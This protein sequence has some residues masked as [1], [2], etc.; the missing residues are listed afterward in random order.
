V[1][2]PIVVNFTNHLKTDVKL[3]HL[4]EV[5]ICD[6]LRMVPVVENNIEL[7]CAGTSAYR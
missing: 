6:L 7:G 3:P 5:K 2:P 4:A 1:S